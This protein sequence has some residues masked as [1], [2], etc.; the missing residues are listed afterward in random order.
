MSAATSLM[1]NRRST[2]LRWSV[3]IGGTMSSRVLL[4][5]WAFLFGGVVVFGLI[6]TG[7]LELVLL[8]HAS[9]F[10]KFAFV[11][12]GSLPFIAWFAVFFRTPE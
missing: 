3:S 2:R 10:E 7:V 1:V 6:S 12:L 5:M 8:R 4:S 11:V 9:L